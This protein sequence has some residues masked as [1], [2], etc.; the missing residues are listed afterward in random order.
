MIRCISWSVAVVKHGLD[1]NVYSNAFRLPMTTGI[2][3]SS[4][5]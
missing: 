1:N 5:R 4:I 3:E 2:Q